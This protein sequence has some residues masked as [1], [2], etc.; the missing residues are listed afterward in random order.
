M[1]WDACCD[2]A[3]TYVKYDEVH[4]RS[5]MGDLKCVE[6]DYF[7]SSTSGYGRGGEEKVYTH[8]E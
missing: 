5:E 2:W 1:A 4:W 7:Y 3:L 8:I 6:G